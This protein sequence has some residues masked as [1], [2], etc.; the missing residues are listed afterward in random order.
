MRGKTYTIK[1]KEQVKQLI[2]L[3]KSYKEITMITGVP[4]STISTW[5]GKITD[6][7][8]N[9][10][11][12]RKHF[13]RIHKLAI[14]AIKKKW[15]EKRSNE[16]LFIKSK[17]NTELKRYPYKNIIVSKALLAMLYWAEGSKHKRVSGTK[18]ANTDPKLTK[19]YV[20]LLRNCYDI[21][22]SKF[23]IRMYLH[24]YHSIKKTK[25]FWSNL[26]DIPV[27]QF[28]KVYIK[29]RSKTKRF[30]KNFAGICFVYYGNSIIRKELLELGMEL[31]RNITNARL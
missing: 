28:N 9:S 1:D 30:R 3:G 22:E 10:L 18:F 11:S 12:R 15:N 7:P 6:K 19:L 17:V 21:D 14:M 2:F 8:L 13:N 23:R 16:D 24:Y 27:C 31:Q 29:K 4:K 26:L 25:N 5:F 20:T